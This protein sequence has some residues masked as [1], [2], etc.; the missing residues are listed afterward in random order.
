MLGWIYADEV[1]NKASSHSISKDDLGYRYKRK[2]SS[3]LDAGMFYCPYVPLQMCGKDDLSHLDDMD[4][5]NRS[6]KTFKTRYG[7]V[8]NPFV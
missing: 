8:T 1:P 7:M 6:I 5:Y 4:K 2:G 3:A